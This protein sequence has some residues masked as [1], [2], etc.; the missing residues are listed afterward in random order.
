MSLTAPRCGPLDWDLIRL[1]G[2]R[3]PWAAALIK[4]LDE[5][6]HQREK[7]W[8]GNPP[9][10]QSEWT[11][12]F[13]CD[14]DAVRLKFD[15]G[16]PAEHVCPQCGAVYTG[17]PWD[18]AWRSLVH[19]SL[20]SNL[21][22]A[23]I[24]ARV[25]SDPAR[26]V[27]CLRRI[28]LFYA[29]NYADY[30]VHGA[31]AGKG[32]IMSQCLDEAIILISIGR[33]LAWGKGAGWFS[34]GELDFIAEKLFRPAVDLLKPQ[35]S[36]IHNIHAWM[37]SALAT[38]ASLLK[39]DELLRWAIESE[40]GWKAQIREG[41]DDDGF[42]YEGSIGYH[43]YTVSA[44]F[45][46]ALT[47]SDC[48]ISLWDEPKLRPMLEGPL[49][50]VYPNGI[51]PAH[52][53]C[54]P[55]VSLF[56]ATGI[57]ELGATAWPETEFSGALGW[58][59]K[60]GNDAGSCKLWTS[61]GDLAFAPK[62]SYAR[63]STTAL[64]YGPGKIG[65]DYEPSRINRVFKSGGIGI[66]ENREIRVCMRFGKDGGGH[67]HR[68]KLNVDVFCS[69]GWNSPDVGTSGYGAEITNK[70]YKTSASHNIVVVNEEKQG[71]SDGELVAFDGNSLAARANAAYPAGVKLS[72]ALELTSRGWTDTFHV[73]CAQVSTLD[74]FFHGDGTIT[75]SLPMKA[76]AGFGPGNGYDW[77]RDPVSCP[78]DGDWEICWTHENARVRLRMQACPGTEVFIGVSD[79]NPATRTLGV[80]MVRRKADATA[81]RADF[82][83]VS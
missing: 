68:D 76:V 15:I 69:N 52:N 37:Q 53:D 24:L 81:F 23:A 80:A 77:I 39:D 54:W 20:V 36:K 21:E 13:Y 63:N 62:S 30:P 42:W 17:E 70:W 22:R 67:D 1:K 6:F 73:E 11:H 79:D 60:H 19:S 33:N 46:L 26:Y 5:A 45:S 28:I 71:H 12:H 35:I 72:R 40:F 25:T 66:L 48:G 55:G 7:D 8:P 78:V 43:F 74:W 9:K 34:E 41:V 50:L 59:Y 58:I 61:T 31:H 2:S 82:E 57:Y 18:G 32:R 49:G 65:T 47:A 10:E 51:F 83:C 56:G 38:A 64:L 16:K 29:E 75:T 4:G 44:L 14:H 27:A 3:E